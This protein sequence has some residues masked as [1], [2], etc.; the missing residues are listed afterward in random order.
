MPFAGNIL[1][2]CIQHPTLRLRHGESL[3]IH[4]P[5]SF[6]LPPKTRVIQGQKDALFFLHILFLEIGTARLQQTHHLMVHFVVD[7]L[8]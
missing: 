6:L 2:M 1:G 7:S 8:C 4:F 5:A 3:A